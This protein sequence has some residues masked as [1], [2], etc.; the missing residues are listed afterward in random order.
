[1]LLG[2]AH[3]SVGAARLERHVLRRR[4]RVGHDPVL[5]PD[6]SVR[7]GVPGEPVPLQRPVAVPKLHL[8]PA[9]AAVACEKQQ[10]VEV[11]AGPVEHGGLLDDDREQ[12]A[13][14]TAADHVPHRLEAGVPAPLRAQVEGHAVALARVHHRL[15]LRQGGRHRLLAV[16][17]P[18]AVLGGMDGDLRPALR[19]RGDADDVGPLD[20]DHP[21]VVQVLLLGR[22]PVLPADLRHHLGPQVRARHQ[23]RALA[24][25]VGG[26]MR[27]RA[28]DILAVADLV[29]DEGA[30]AAAADEDGPVRVLHGVSAYCRCAGR[31]TNRRRLDPARSE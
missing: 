18:R 4:D 31:A 8:H 11:V 15:R 2:D 23:L 26:G 6:P 24:R 20:V 7:I 19:L 29:V 27:I 22:D 16:D 14:P 28:Q 13:Q 5:E 9:R 25:A 21:P 30:H 10:V 12:G 1:M 3:G 17:R